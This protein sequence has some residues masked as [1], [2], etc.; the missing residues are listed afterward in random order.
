MQIFDYIVVGAG[1]SGCSL[2]RGLC[3]NPDNNVLLLEAGPSANRFWVNTPAGMAKL[4]FNEKLNWN[5]HTTPMA[6]LR[7]RKMYWPR[8]KL[9]GGSSSINGMV[10]IRGHQKDFDGW[11]NLGNPGWGY[12]DVL[13]YFKKMESFERGGDDYRGVSGPLWISD[14]VVKEQSS[15]DFIEA[16]TRQ[17]VPFTE[18]MNGALHDGVGF[19]QHN[20]RDGGRLSAYRAFIEPVI[21]RKNLTVRT[22]CEVQR[23]LFKGH[24]AIGV[25]ILRDGRRESIY[26]AREV[27]MSAGS[28]KTPQLLMLSGVGPSAEL[29]KHAIPLVQ[30]IPGVGQ[31]LQDHFYIHTGFRCTPDSSYNANLTG[32]RK[33]WEGFR[34]LM[35]RKGYLAL[36]SSQVAAFVKSRPEEDYADLQISF[37]PMTFQYFPDGTVAVEPEPGVGVSV[38]QLRPSTTGT[39]TLRS[40]NAS[41]PADYTPNFLTNEYDINAVI[42]GIRWIRKIMD[43][44][45]IKSRIVGEE[46]PGIGVQTDE[47]IYNYLVETGNSAHHQAGTCKM[48]NDPMAVVDERLRV[49]GLERLRV[50]DAS[51]MPFV[52]SGNTNAPSIM[53]GVKAADMI[54]EDAV[55]RQP[56]ADNHQIKHA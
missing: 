44:E 18:D 36:G 43:S 11:R 46:V 26:A 54:I 24:T 17:G 52:T 45:P 8:G 41:D 20:I 42:S 29:R 9:L 27:I 16:A 28:L 55:A 53:I 5:F 19:M 48:G 34:Y 21:E 47:E 25:E 32:V 50:V 6:N 31:N 4:Y 23:V 3:D 12:D 2:A 10:F 39:V 1:S 40:T 13:P 35:T 15:Y 49:R 22:G 51:I 37:R 30:D 7:D 38:Y 14:P 56:L 33:Y